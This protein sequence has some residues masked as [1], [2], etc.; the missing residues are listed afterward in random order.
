M[1]HIINFIIILF[2]SSANFSQ[3]ICEYYCQL[4]SWS[5]T[6][7]SCDLIVPPTFVE[8]TSLSNDQIYA[9][10]NTDAT[11]TEQL[12][13][14]GATDRGIVDAEQPDRGIINHLIV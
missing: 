12:W 4:N 1:R 11:T 10:L 6:A 8:P 7:N 2:F 9:V 13:V 3:N 5:T 14:D